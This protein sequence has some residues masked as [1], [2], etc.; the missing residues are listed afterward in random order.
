MH[1]NSSPGASPVLFPG[2]GCLQWK[3]QKW[4][5]LWGGPRW[6]HWRSF[7]PSITPVAYCSQTFSQEATVKW[8]H[9]WKDY[10]AGRCP[11]YWNVQKGAGMSFAWISFARQGQKRQDI[12]SYSFFPLLR[13][14]Y[15]KDPVL[16]KGTGA[17]GSL[18]G[19]GARSVHRD[20]SLCVDHEEDW[21]KGRLS[22]L[23]LD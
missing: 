7:A 16:H 22:W 15:P 18:A 21:L 23:H 9:G 20:S 13:W 4:Q 10:W 2:A 17:E 5:C 1:V 14:S 19:E 11:L 3:G 6:L 12:L 8:S